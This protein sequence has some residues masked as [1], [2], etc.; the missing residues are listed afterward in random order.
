MHGRGAEKKPGLL[1]E[2]SEKTAY[3]S[4][5]YYPLWLL[6]TGNAALVINGLNISAHEFSF[7]E[8]TKTAAFI[9]EMKK[10][11]AHPQQLLE[12]L[13]TQ[14]REI[15]EFTTPNHQTFPAVINDKELLSYL[16]EYLQTGALQNPNQTN[17][18]IPTEIDEQNRLANQPNI[19]ELPKNHT[20]PHKRTNLRPNATQRRV[21]VSN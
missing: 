6:S 2:S 13:K 19:Q 8:P 18:A 4:K 20:S 5:V 3:V 16:T 21:G 15:K 9:E 10:N 11:S 14:N 1:R 12:A 7:D 17:A